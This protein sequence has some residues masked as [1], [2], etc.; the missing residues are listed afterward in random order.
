VVAVRGEQPGEDRPQLQHG[1][2]LLQ[3]DPPR[4]QRERE[5]QRLDRQQRPGVLAFLQADGTGV[6]AGG[7]LVRARDHQRLVLPAQALPSGGI[8][9]ARR[10]A[11]HA[12]HRPEPARVELRYIGVQA[13]VSGGARGFARIRVG[14]DSE[15][16]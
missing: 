14:L 8:C 15:S 16:G 5:P 7:E 3:R 4:L 12:P 1:G 2:D 10:G 11:D 9:L 6:V 13:F